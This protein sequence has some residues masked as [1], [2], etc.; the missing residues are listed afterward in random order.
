MEGQQDICDFIKG[1]QS[2]LLIT[3]KLLAEATYSY[4]DWFR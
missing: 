2:P 4:Y 1:Q 3:K